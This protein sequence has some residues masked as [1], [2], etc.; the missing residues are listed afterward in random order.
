MGSDGTGSV[1]C[2]K[3]PI[4][5]SVHTHAENLVGAQELFIHNEHELQLIRVRERERERDL[6]FA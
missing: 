5:R 6:K 2:L 3:N 1:G 4:K